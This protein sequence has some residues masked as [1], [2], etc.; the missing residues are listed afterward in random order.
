MARGWRPFAGGAAAVLLAGLVFA[1]LTDGAGRAPP[2]TTAGS[3][4]G[5]ASSLSAAAADTGSPSPSAASPSPSPEERTPEPS[6]RS[7]D[8]FWTFE[9]GRDPRWESFSP[10]ISA[11]GRFITFESASDDL[12]PDD[13]GD[14]E[15][16]FVRDGLNG[17]TT[18]VSKS[19]AGRQGN[20]HSGASVISGDGR[21]ITFVSGASN[22][23]PADRNGVLDVFV[24]DRR[25][26]TTDR[27]SVSSAGEE[28]NA[29]SG[30]PDISDD[31]RWIVFS[32][33]ATNLVPD[34]TNGVRDVFLHDRHSGSTT[35]VSATA[36]G[37][38]SDRGSNNPSVSPEGRWVAFTSEATSLDA[39]A[40][41]GN[42]VPAPAKVD[43]QDCE[44]VFLWNRRTAEITAVSVSEDGGASN[45]P[46]ERSDVSTD[47]RYVAFYSSAS[48]LAPGDANRDGWDVYVRDIVEGE[49]RLVTRSATGDDQPRLSIAITPDGRFI[50]FISGAGDLLRADSNAC[51]VGYGGEEPDVEPCPDGFLYDREA[52]R[53]H[54]VSRAHDGEQADDRSFS[55]AISASGRYVTFDSAATNLVSGRRQRCFEWRNCPDVFVRDRTRGHTAMVS[56]ARP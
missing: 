54:L 11:D 39:H 27:V 50:A 51:E 24:H 28:A 21:F 41:D 23:V 15:E 18:L 13:R 33:D 3:P 31:G 25:R 44:D 6:K 34:D 22:L 20:D 19:S 14:Y 55:A 53:L 56:H 43:K 7:G 2:V 1:S 32:S 40:G 12:V 5:V 45:G 46:S 36:D 38:Q 8:D 49:T 42:C 52:G 10:S 35:L 17:R 16:I 47:G 26:G 30:G 37:T 9:V 48:D 4:D 29:R